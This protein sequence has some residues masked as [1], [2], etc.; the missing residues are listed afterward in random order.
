M[1]TLSFYYLEI[2]RFFEAEKIK[3]KENI[4]WLKVLG[5]KTTKDL[6]FMRKII[7]ENV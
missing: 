3:Q 1:K 7:K 5:Q 2:N 6:L 4:N